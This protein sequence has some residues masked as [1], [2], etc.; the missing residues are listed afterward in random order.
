MHAGGGIWS[1][2]ETRSRRSRID[3]PDLGQ[4]NRNE[5]HR[6]MTDAMGNLMDLRPSFLKG[7]SSSGTTSRNVLQALWQAA[8]MPM[9][10]WR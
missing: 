10:R 2:H 4:C 1:N 8:G 7:R 9:K 3:G 6:K 5:D